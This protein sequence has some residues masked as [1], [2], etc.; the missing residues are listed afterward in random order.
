MERIGGNLGSGATMLYPCSILQGKNAKSDNISVVVASKHQHQDVG[1]KVIHIGEHTSS[2]IV[3]KS[4]SKD[5]G[6]STYRGL[7]KIQSSAT[8]A[9]H[10]TKCDALL[11]DTVSRS[12]TVPAINV[13]SDDATVSHEATAGKIDTIQLFYLMSRGLSEEKAMAMIVNGFLASIVKKL[14]MEYAGELNHIIE[15]EMEGS[16]G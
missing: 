8:H 3:S 5:G 1:A 7:V 4:I 15:M 14:P 12:D 6:V 10:S 11:L 9:T 2:N 13:H 16:I